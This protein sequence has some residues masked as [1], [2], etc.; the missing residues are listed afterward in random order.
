MNRYLKLIS[1]TI[2]CVVVLKM[3]LPFQESNSEVRKA[4]WTKKTYAKNNYD[5][6]ACGDSRIYRGISPD[7]MNE[8]PKGLNFLNLGYSSAGLSEEYLDFVVSK[9]KSDAT[10]KILVVGVSPNS[11]LREAQKNEQLASFQNQGVF[12]TFRYTYLSPILQNFAPYKPL[13][14]ITQEPKNYQE[15][16]DES[17]WV[18]SDQLRPDSTHALKIYEKMLSESTLEKELLDKTINKLIEIQESGVQIFAIRMPTTQAMEQLEDRLLNYDEKM[19]KTP[20]VEKGIIWMSFDEENFIS[21]D[22]SHLDSES[23]LRISK[24]IGKRISQFI[25]E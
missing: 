3:L 19:V 15:T 24:L 18:K 5:V 14:L 16:F 12:A 2:I 4:F 9:F 20:L 1:L 7:L 23:S 8:L 6:I 22:G 11:L 17:G 13:Q 25:N 21:Y 10:Q